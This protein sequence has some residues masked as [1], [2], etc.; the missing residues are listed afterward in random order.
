[1]C[2]HKRRTD[3]GFTLFEL[4]VVMVVIAVISAISAP[5]IIKAAT[6]QRDQVA[7]TSAEAVVD[8]EEIVFAAQRSYVD[9]EELAERKLAGALQNT[10][11]LVGDRGSCFTAVAVSKNGT[12]FL[13]ENTQPAFMLTATTGPE[14]ISDTKMVEVASDLGADDTILASRSFKFLPKPENAV[15]KGGR[16]TWDAVDGATKYRIERLESAWVLAATATATQWSASPRPLDGEKIR[17]RIVAVNATTESRPTSVIA[18]RDS[19]KN[20]LADGDLWVAASAW[21]LTSAAFEHID[22]TRSGKIV[23]A[24][25]G[26]MSQEFP[27]PADR[28][29][30][31]MLGAFDGTY[32]F[33]AAATISWYTGEA[34]SPLGTPISTTT[35]YTSISLA[36]GPGVSVTPPATATRGVFKIAN[37]STTATFNVTAARLQ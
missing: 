28:P 37:T 18:T 14:C 7:L 35:A 29:S 24:P 21:T 32:P 26:S 8:A 13:S 3:R 33:T 12:V 36:T 6:G 30:M 2:N 5:N 4:I 31:H 34:G 27:V 10:R 15:Y 25:L 20:R 16:L 19:A 23:I 1:M 22:Q 17:F 11:I 9:H